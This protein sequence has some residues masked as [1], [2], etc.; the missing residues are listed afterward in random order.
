MIEHKLEVGF[1]ARPLRTR[2]VVQV[3]ELLYLEHFRSKLLILVQP[4]LLHRRLGYHAESQGKEDVTRCDSQ[5]KEDSFGII[6]GEHVSV[7]DRS[8]HVEHQV[9]AQEILFT[10]RQL[11]QTVVIG[12]GV[13][14]VR[15]DNQVQ[16]VPGARYEVTQKEQHQGCLEETHHVIE[17]LEVNF[18]F[19]EDLQRL[20]TADHTHYS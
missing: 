5:A 14:L 18:K 2:Y 19:C 1:Y 10:Q 11:V 15:L 3:H 8:Y 12:P 7:A 6:H 20:P 16:K 4:I 9:V 17:S 13:L